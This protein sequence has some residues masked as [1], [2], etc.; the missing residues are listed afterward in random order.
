[1]LMFK[2]D[3]HVHSYF[4]GPAKHLRILRCR[5]S[6]S[7]PWAVYQTA[8]RRGMDLVTISDH[9]SIDGCLELLNKHELD[10]F[11]IG[12]EV[13]TYVPEFRHHVHVGVYDITE[14]QHREVQRLRGDVR[15]LVG[16]LRSQNVLYALN[17]FFFEFKHADRLEQYMELM[18]ELFDVFEEQ[19]GAM[20]RVHNLLVS[21]LLQH[22]ERGGKRVS[23][24]GGS[25]SH[26]LRRIGR[27]YT[28]AE[29]ARNR[30]EFLEAIRAGRTYVAGQHCN[31]WQ[32]AGDIY[33]VVLRYYP[34]IVNINSGEFSLFKRLRNLGIS[35]G[36]LPF[37]ALPYLVAVRHT[38]SE[39]ERLRLFA[40]KTFQEMA[41]VPKRRTGQ[42]A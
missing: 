19:N 25:D 38:R 4:S 6:Y 2:A 37:M 9:D 18:G 29:D 7:S 11:I 36:L 17:H 35:L 5:D 20:Q 41:P 28:V 8:K 15:E 32:L 34:Y 10:D 30:R 22:M 13:T 40:E 39:R 12:E 33:G 3:L 31:Q 16:Y 21:Q 1:V 24:I 26:T 27:T 14:E 42:T 23:R